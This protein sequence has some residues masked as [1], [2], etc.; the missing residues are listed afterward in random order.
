[1]EEK[2][3]IA[4]FTLAELSVINL[5]LA[6]TEGGRYGLL[7][8]RFKTLYKQPWG[9]TD[10]DINILLSKA[11]VEALTELLNDPRNLGVQDTIG[12]YE[13]KAAMSKLINLRGQ[14]FRAQVDEDVKAWLAGEL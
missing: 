2:Q 6:E 12:G 11:D 8:T 14:F 10:T 1:M 13:W 7:A 3:I 4:G 9:S 5:A